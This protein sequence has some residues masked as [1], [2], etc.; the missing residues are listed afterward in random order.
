VLGARVRGYWKK[1]GA[2]TPVV[3]KKNLAM[4]TGKK[5][6]LAVA[7][8]PR[9]DKVFVHEVGKNWNSSSAIIMYNRLFRWA[10]K[11]SGNAASHKFR[12]LEDNDRVYKSKKIREEKSRKFVEEIIPKRSPDIQAL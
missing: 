6:K 4:N 2:A 11:V 1:K 12:L 10:L 8:Y 5:L 3:P 9:F 7:Y